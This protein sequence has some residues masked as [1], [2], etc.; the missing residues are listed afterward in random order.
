LI[1]NFIHVVKLRR[2]GVFRLIVRKIYSDL[3]I[4]LF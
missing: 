3:K 1:L 2:E 4:N